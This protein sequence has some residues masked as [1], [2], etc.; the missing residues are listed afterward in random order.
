MPVTWEHA[1]QSWE[2]GRSSFLAGKVGEG[3]VQE[4]ADS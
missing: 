4:A 1:A 2:K 3:F